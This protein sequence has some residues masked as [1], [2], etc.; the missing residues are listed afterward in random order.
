[1]M[2]PTQIRISFVSPDGTTTEGA[3]DIPDP[4][5]VAE[6]RERES[7][8]TESWKQLIDS[9]VEA[10]AGLLVEMIQNCSF[11]VRPL[12]K[13]F[14]EAGQSKAAFQYLAT[15][16]ITDQARQAFLPIWTESGHHIR[17]E[18][19]DDVILLDALWKLLPAYQGPAVQLFRGEPWPDFVAQQHGICWSSDPEAAEVYARG[20]NA[21][22]D[23]GGVLIET[24]APIE[25]I[26]SR[27]ATGGVNGW[28]AEYLIDRRYLPE[29]R[30]LRRF[31]QV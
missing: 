10:A 31:P 16:T 4:A 23:G 11:R 26:I 2:G 13:C 6:E 5:L 8:E 22:Y 21:M 28:E 18:V 9:D 14:H 24:L 29:I 17:R 19:G 3:L 15:A 1:M 27:G 20:L 30:Q 25:A 12:L 7:R